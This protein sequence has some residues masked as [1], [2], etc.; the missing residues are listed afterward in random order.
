MANRELWN[1]RQIYRDA[2]TALHAKRFQD[3]GE[4]THLTIEIEVGQRAAI[5]GLTLP[6]EG[7]LVSSRSAYVAIDRN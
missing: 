6:H 3:V 1:E 2:I 5:A 7:C 4:L